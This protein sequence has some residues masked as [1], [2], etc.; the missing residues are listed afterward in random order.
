MTN[1]TDLFP[2]F[3]EEVIASTQIP[4]CQ[5]HNPP[6]MSLAQIKQYQP[7]IGWFIP[8]E[9][10][11][12]AELKINHNWQP[13]RLTFAEDTSNPREVDGFLASHLR[14]CVLHT[15][16][17]EV[18][19]R[20]KKGWRYCGLAYEY[21]H[22]TE[23][24]QLA[25]SDRHHFRLRTCYLVM[26]LDD[27]HQ[28]IHSTPLKIGMNAGVGVAFATELK[29]FRTEIETAYFQT[30]QEPKKSLSDRAHALT[31]FDFQL[32][33]HKSEGKAPFIYPQQRFTPLANSSC[34][35]RD[36]PVE[37]IHQPLESL[38]IPKASAAGQTLLFLHA[39]YQN[40]FLHNSDEAATD[41]N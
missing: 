10:A 9:Q 36:R 27:N 38:I 30:V 15:S 14:I 8:A 21:G 25:Q 22:L 4:F 17:I 24:G 23:Y 28:P 16:Q 18:Q 7:P 3:E 34:H 31:V 12:Q 40:F 26:F 6:N 29:Q 19:E 2:G 35:R 33:C 13:L 41:L 1:S 20:A 11:Q 32:G 5:V 37:L 39:E